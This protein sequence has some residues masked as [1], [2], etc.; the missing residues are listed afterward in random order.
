MARLSPI[1]P[2]SLELIKGVECEIGRARGKIGDAVK[3]KLNTVLCRN[4]GYATMCKISDILSG[5]E[6]TLGEDEPALYS[7][8]LKCRILINDSSFLKC[9]HITTQFP[10]RAQCIR[11]TCTNVI[12]H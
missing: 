2:I 9:I 8:D 10:Q 5:N 3:S 6:A 4:D 7:N 12:A 11:L 1:L